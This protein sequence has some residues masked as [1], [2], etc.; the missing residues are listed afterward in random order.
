MNLRIFKLAA[1]G[2]L[3]MVAMFWPS[4]WNEWQR[5]V[6]ILES[7]ARDIQGQA[8]DVLGASNSADVYRVSRVVDGDTLKVIIAD[9]EE[10]VRIVGIN[11]PETVDPRRSVECFGK[12]ASLRAQ[13][14]LSG[15]LVRLERDS[16]QSDRDRYQ[17]LLR[18]VFLADGT[19][20]GLQ[21]IQ[22]G[23]A[24]ESLYSSIPH[25]YHQLYVTAEE[26]ARSSQVG[27]WASDACL[28]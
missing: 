10:T 14:L 20:V 5:E 27:L 12:E 21:L 6:A 8:V 24:M 28:K 22:E 23:M 16:T 9:K 13:E 11:T 25:Q 18:F 26:A 15:Q 3:L 2:L 17:R 7:T 1:L 4:L 19:D